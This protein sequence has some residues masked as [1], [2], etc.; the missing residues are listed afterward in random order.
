M[1]KGLTPVV[2]GRCTECGFVRNLWVKELAGV[3]PC[4]HR[5]NGCRGELK[6][7]YSG[8]KKNVPPE[9]S[10]PPQCSCASRQAREAAAAEQVAPVHAEPE[11]ELEPS[12]GV[13]LVEEGE[14]PVVASEADADNGKNGSALTTGLTVAGGLAAAGLAAFA[15]L[16]MTGGAR[17]DS[18]WKQQ[19]QQQQQ[20]DAEQDKVVMEAQLERLQAQL[21]EKTAAEGRLQ[22]QLAGKAAAEAEAAEQTNAAA[23]PATAVVQQQQQQQQQPIGSQ[24]AQQTNRE[25]QLEARLAQAHEQLQRQ[26]V[27]GAVLT[28]IAAEA[29]QRNAELEDQIAALHE[30]ARAAEKG[31]EAPPGAALVVYNAGSDAVNGWY[32]ICG[33]KNG[34]PCY[35]QI[36]ADSIQIFVHND[37]FIGTGRGYPDYTPNERWGQAWVIRSHTEYI[38]RLSVGSHAMGGCGPPPREPPESGWE[39]N[40]TTAFP[41]PFIALV[42]DGWVE[43]D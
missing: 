21:A 25:Q 12:N 28:S 22:A 18:E 10:N 24:R 17:E 26:A 14:P 11:P 19:Q 32:Q 39:P 36:G 33:E 40:F 1:F 35:S 20:R 15:A 27:G 41:A 42:V 2:R 13:A 16:K 30:S 29:Q 9:L 31:I 7:A 43:T 8:P 37:V 4:D 38:N 3:I 23:A 34:W 6:A 5:D